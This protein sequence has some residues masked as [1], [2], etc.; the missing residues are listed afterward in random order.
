L[1]PNYEKYPSF[2]RFYLYPKDFNYDEFD[3]IWLLMTGRKQVHE[4]LA[5]ID[6]VRTKLT[7]YLK[8][9]HNEKLSR[10][11]VSYYL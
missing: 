4:K 10:I 1:F 5:E 6:A 2:W 3:P 7:K 8:E 9:T 11:F